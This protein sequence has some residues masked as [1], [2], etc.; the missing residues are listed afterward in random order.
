MM[1]ER[2]RGMG[3]MVVSRSCGAIGDIAAQVAGG[4]GCGEVDG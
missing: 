1:G 3:L 2:K 4:S